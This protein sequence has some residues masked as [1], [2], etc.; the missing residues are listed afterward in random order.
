MD[1]LTRFDEYLQYD[2]PAALVIVEHLAPVEGP[3]AVL[4]PPTFAAGGSFRGGY[5][6]DTFPDGRNVCLVDSVGSQAN[7]I[8]KI[9]LYEQYSQLVPQV[10]VIAGDKEVS[11]FEIGH[12]AGDALIR[13]SSAQTDFQSAFKSQLSGNSEPLA[14]LAPTSL[15]FGVWDSRDTQ[16]KLPRL[17]ASTIRA[18]N[19]RQLTRGAIYNPPVDY[20]ALDI[21][22]ED[23]KA[24]AEGDNKSPIARRGFVH[25]PASA[26]PGG[27]IADGG[28]RRDASLS[29]SALRQLHAG[30]DRNRTLTLRRYV[31]ALS[32]VALTA[33]SETYLRQGCQL[34]TRL[35]E[36]GTPQREFLEVY[37]DG[38]RRPCSA[39][40]KDALRFAEAAANAFGIAEPR[41]IPFKKELAQ[42]DVKD[43]DS[44]GKNK[45]KSKKG[46]PA[47][48]ASDSI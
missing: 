23:D 46:S 11:I 25:N 47:T 17:I 9:F 14:R 40:H 20:T 28:I 44:K 39:S 22:S 33:P 26:A 13:C 29:L 4:F 10:S 2:G 42:Q 48:E 41:K 38:S 34:V 36:D 15:V 6:I 5:N 35:R 16:A 37:P 27:V 43:D 32:L 12:R 1:I 3:E 18:Y 19:V 8:E 30:H 24:K 7:R 21:F 45:N 31:L